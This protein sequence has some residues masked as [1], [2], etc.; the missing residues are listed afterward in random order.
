MNRF[1]SMSSKKIIVLIAYFFLVLPAEA[2]EINLTVTGVGSTKADA[3]IDAQRNA[4]R[5]SYG[6]FISS[7]I[8]VVNNELVKNENVNLVNGTIKKFKV[9]SVS[10]NTF[11]DPPIF[12]VLI[13][14]TT[15]QESLMAF[16]KSI[17]VDVEVAG[18]LFG[19]QFKLQ[20]IN[21]RNETTAM[22][23]L[24]KRV[25]LVSNLFDYKLEVKK[26]T[27]YK[28]KGWSE[29]DDYEGTEERYGISVYT[30]L[31][32][33][34]NYLNMRDSI[35][36]TLR[37][38]NMKYK[39]RQEYASVGRETYEIHFMMDRE[40]DCA[41]YQSDLH[42]G[43]GGFQKNLKSDKFCYK[44]DHFTKTELKS[45]NSDRKHV[46][47]TENTIRLRSKK[48]IE[49]LIKIHDEVYRKIH[50]YK[51]NRISGAEKNLINKPS[52]REDMNMEQYDEKGKINP[53]LHSSNYPGQLSYFW[54]G[55]Y[56]NG[57][58][59]NPFRR[60][61]TFI[62]I[63]GDSRQRG[64]IISYEEKWSKNFY[65]DKMQINTVN[66]SSRMDIGTENCEGNWPSWDRRSLTYCDIGYN[67]IRFYEKGH[68][69][70][71]LY[72][73]DVVTESELS[74]I[75]KYEIAIN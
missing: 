51:L 44:T 4:L 1:K 20:K 33:N 18:S 70:A 6:E 7:D 48:S 46:T 47:S 64:I 13:D 67:K 45:K 24:L 41:Y 16:S 39:E 50:R 43:G 31:I 8:S 66:E 12:E 21:Q 34:D 10:E 68:P 38:I 58:Q 22:E 56:G 59:E 75:S 53:R 55:G 69:F 52:F 23:H 36:S 30:P 14:V 5:I 32:A 17:G 35:I 49:I 60:I 11:S 27:I 63:F 28:I 40:G 42:Y 25:Q 54:T 71:Y 65:I 15:S 19:A 61:S 72:W 2:E 62:S 29:L 3:I 74:K 37:S 26:P 9:I 57:V 73:T